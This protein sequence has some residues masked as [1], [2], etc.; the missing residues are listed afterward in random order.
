[1]RECDTY[2]EII[3]RV[4][5]DAASDGERADLE[6]HMAA[7]RACA[8]LYRSMASSLD[9]LIASP[10]PAPA[11]DFT[12]KTVAGALRA[13]RVRA[14]RRNCIAGCILGLMLALSASLV[15]EWASAFQPLVRL[16]LGRMLRLLME[17][18]VLCSVFDKLQTILT[19]VPSTVGEALVRG[20]LGTGG[21]AF[22][23]CLMTLLLAVF[24]LVWSGIRMSG[25]STKR[26]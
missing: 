17:G 21:T 7:C 1:M 13:A 8:G 25:V 6:R 11:P 12:A 16:G 15:V 10:V 22:W 20:I 14:R 9:L 2:R 18:M 5:D 24:I 4:L 23:G 19:V 26:R 3:Q